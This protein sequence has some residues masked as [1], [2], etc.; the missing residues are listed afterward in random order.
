M[1]TGDDEQQRFVAEPKYFVFDEIHEYSELFGSF[2]STLMRRYIRERQE[3]NGYD[4]EAE[5]DLTIV[6]A[7]ATVENKR[8]VFQRINP[9]VDP[10]VEVI[11]EDEQTLNAP[12]P[13]DIHDDFLSA[14][15][16]D[17]ELRDRTTAA[18]RRALDAA[19]VEGGSEDIEEAFYE[20]LVEDE[21]G[22]LEFVRGIYA[23]LH[24][25]PLK[26]VGLRDRLIDESGLSGVTS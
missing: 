19:G 14:E 9:F 25:T 12:F 16:G 13:V 6:G 8:T 7:S 4:S 11:E 23:A 24:E 22:P 2:T 20:H 15:L 17:E 10:D 5:D 18:A 21:G 3:L 26:P 1:S